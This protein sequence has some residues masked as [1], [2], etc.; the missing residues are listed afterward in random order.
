MLLVFVDED[1]DLARAVVVNIN[2][3]SEQLDVS[4]RVTSRRPWE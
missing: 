2:G 3:A 4:T 1:V